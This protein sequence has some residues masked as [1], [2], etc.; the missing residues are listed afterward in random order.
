MDV[1]DTA[2]VYECEFTSKVIIMVI[3]NGLH[4]KEMKHNLLSL[5]ITRLSR[6]ELNKQPKFMTR[7]PTTE[8]H[9]VSFKENEIRLPLAIKVMVSFPSHSESKIEE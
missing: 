5:S 6:L 3:R 1:V 2:I 8:H 9:S 4:L 7:N